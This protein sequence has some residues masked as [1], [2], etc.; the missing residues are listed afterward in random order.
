MA[1]L[2]RE[3]RIEHLLR[4][5]AFGAGQD[6][7]G[8]FIELGSF[9]TLQFLLDY[10]TQPDDLDDAIG[11]PGYVGVTARGE[12]LP[13]TSITDARQRWLFRM[14]HSQRPLQ[15]KMALFWHNHFATA[16]SKV[17]GA[18]GAEVGAQMMAANPRTDTAQV[19]GQVELFRQYALGNFRDLVVEVAK[20]PAMLV[21]LDGRLN[22][23]DRPQENFGREVLELFTMGVGNYTEDDIYSATRVFTGWNLRRAPGASG[24]R[25]EFVYNAGQHDTSAKRFSFPIYPDGSSTIPARPAANGQQDGLDFI[26]AIVAHPA[27]GRRLARKLWSFFVSELRPAPE[28]WV[29]AVAGVFTTGGYQ[30]KPVVRAVL[31]SAE[32]YSP[33]NV[34]ARYSWPVEF[35]IRALKEAGWLGFSVQSALTPLAN[36]GQ[37]L[38]EPPDVNG[39]ELGAGWFSTSSMLARMNFASTVA[40]NQRVAVRDLLKPFARTPDALLAYV[41]DRLTARPFER[42]A[43]ETLREYLV[44]GRPWTGSDADLLVKGPGLVHLVMA[45]P[46]YQAI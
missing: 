15:E 21:W 25:Y 29:D 44:A 11:I 14:V 23:R 18:F 28:S 30:M 6:E 32:F 45:S 7:L 16:Y 3:E 19:K 22:T 4:R 41:L 33:E 34:F 43:R 38:F 24:V 9:G 35:V 39:W 20:D 42:D 17:G 5:A 40:T 13:N 26:N 2:R 8:S 36:M 10:E 1:T 27:T 31:T 37:Q 46:N 12:F